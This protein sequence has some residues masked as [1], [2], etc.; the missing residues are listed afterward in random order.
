MLPC[1]CNHKLILRNNWGERGSTFYCENEQGHRGK[2]RRT[3]G[4]EWVMEWKV[5]GEAQKGDPDGA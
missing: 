3:L 4:N 5:V 2:H 1:N